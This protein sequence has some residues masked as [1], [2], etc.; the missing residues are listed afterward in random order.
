MSH[1]EMRK[2]K[3]R[4]IFCVFVLINR[5]K[6]IHGL[7]DAENHG[8]SWKIWI[9]ETVSSILIVHAES[10][11]VI[12]DPSTLEDETSN[13]IILSLPKNLKKIRRSFH[14]IKGINFII[15]FFIAKL[16]LSL[17]PN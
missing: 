7:E 2:S 1:A 14:S 5:E 6:V 9:K 3:K 16:S 10:L 4:V 15:F 12:L 13:D 8:K 17:Q 11:K